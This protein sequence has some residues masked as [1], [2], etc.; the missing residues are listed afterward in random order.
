M[1]RWIIRHKGYTKLVAGTA[2][3]WLLMVAFYIFSQEPF[4]NRYPRMALA[5]SFLVYAYPIIV[6]A[7][8]L[9]DF[10]DGRVPEDPE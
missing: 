3:V 7:S 4:I 5:L 10:K 8:V 6:I 1:R 9:R 2:V